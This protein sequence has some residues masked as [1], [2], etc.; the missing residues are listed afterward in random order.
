MNFKDKVVWITGASSGIGEGL[1]YALANQGAR[2][3]LSSRNQKELDRVKSN[4]PTQADVAVFP[5]DVADFEQLQS[6]A[7]E[8]E[9]HFG[10]IDILINNAGISQRELARET[11]F[12][13][14]VKITNVNY[15]GT[16]G[17]TKAVL[18][19]MIKRKSGQIVVISSVLG[20]YGVPYRSSYAG[21]KHAL[22]GFFDSLRAEL[23]A[24]K[25][26]IPVT[27][28]CPGYVRTNVTINAMRGD[29]SKNNEMANST[30]GGMTPAEFAAKAL[31][32]IS[33][34]RREVLI[35]GKETF[36]V[37][38]KRFFPGF[39]ANQVKNVKLQ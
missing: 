8:V 4:C 7:D 34:K 23:A 39:F 30:A 28:I 15:L 14:D 20:K 26:N 25:L 27:V 16:V 38:I 6:R 11:D 12:N 21:S 10:Q 9:A 3:A 36:Y 31:K 32:A 18:P 24:E 1:A 19:S 22:Q 17:L 13:V 37:L 35:G 33:S 29:G 5:L 2:L